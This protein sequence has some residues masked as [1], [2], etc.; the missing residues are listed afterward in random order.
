MIK[1]NEVF[2]TMRIP[3]DMKKEIKKYCVDKNLTMKDFCL[4]ALT[5][6]LDEHNKDNESN[7]DKN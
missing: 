1:E 5:C 6:Y 3:S 2:F 7:K 4:K